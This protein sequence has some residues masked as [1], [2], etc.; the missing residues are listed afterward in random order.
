[1]LNKRVN[2]EILKGFTLLDLLTHDHSIRDPFSDF[3]T[4][5]INRYEGEFMPLAEVLDTES[6]IGYG[7]F[8]TN[9]MEESPLIDNLPIGKETAASLSFQDTENFKWQLYQQA[10]SENKTE[11]VIDDKVIE[12][13]SK[14]EFSI[15]GLPDSMHAMVKI[16]ALP[17]TILT[18]A[19]I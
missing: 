2:D 3:K 10:I 12:R 13:L 16:N 6:G 5:F 7:K 9:G 11:V 1:M 8:A 4:A 14:K 18:T 19:I 17:Q 15:A